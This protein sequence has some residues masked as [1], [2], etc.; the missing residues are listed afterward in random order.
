MSCVAKDV[1]QNY[2]HDNENINHNNVLFF[3]VF[4]TQQRSVVKE[5]VNNTLF[6]VALTE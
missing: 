5:V 2:S 6:P 4:G 1:N 3:V